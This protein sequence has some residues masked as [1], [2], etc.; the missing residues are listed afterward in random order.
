MPGDPSKVYGAFAEK[1]LHRVPEGG[2]RLASSWFRSVRGGVSVDDGTLSTPEETHQR[3]EPCGVAAVPKSIIE[4][5]GLHLEMDPEDTEE[6]L[7]KNPSH[8]I[9]R[10]VSSKDCGHITKAAEI[11]FRLESLEVRGAGGSVGIDPPWIVAPVSQ[12]LT[13]AEPPKPIDDRT[14]ELQFDPPKK[15]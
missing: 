9:V 2:Y 7:R 6:D 4:T 15:P 10:G 13:P 8:R 12:A 11:V 3:N 1:H 14:L 5:R